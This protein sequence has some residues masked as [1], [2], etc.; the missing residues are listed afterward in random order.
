METPTTETFQYADVL[1]GWLLGILA[2]PITNYLTSWHEKRRFLRGVG[3]E[4]VDLR[5]RLASVLYSIAKTANKFDRDFLVWIKKELEAY[6]GAYPTVTL[7]T[8]LEGLLQLDTSQVAAL[9]AV[10]RATTEEKSHSIPHF[11]TPYLDAKLDV[12][13]SLSDKQQAFLLNIKRCLTAI[14]SKIDQMGEWDKMSFEVS[15]PANHQGVVGNSKS[16]IV[17]MFTIGK[18]AAQDIKNFQSETC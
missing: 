5:F 7:T 13:P 2:G 3:V 4:L 18:E 14:N 15:E 1:V 16:C 17:S 8:A 10:I 9:D 6:K 11:H 12:L